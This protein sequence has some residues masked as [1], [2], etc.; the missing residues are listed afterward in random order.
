LEESEI[1]EI[2]DAVYNTLLNIFEIYMDN[3]FNDEINEN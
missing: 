1:N 2:Y 3:Y